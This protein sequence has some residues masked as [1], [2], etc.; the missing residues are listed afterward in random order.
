MGP[1]GN[2]RLGLAGRRASVADVE[3]GCSCRDAPLPAAAW[4]GIRAATNFGSSCPP[5][6]H[7][8]MVWIRGGA[9]IH[10][11]SND[12]NAAALVKQCVVVVTINYRLGLL[13]V[14]SHQALGAE[15]PTHS[16]GNYG[17]LDPD[18]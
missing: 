3:S 13:G 5:S 4:K 11:E 6:R 14:L 17:L 7:A 9:L 1:H 15:S 2:A 8:V 16:S 18:P 12:Y 10:G